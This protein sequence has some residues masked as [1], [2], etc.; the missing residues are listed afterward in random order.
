MKLIVTKDTLFKSMPVQSS[1][2]RK[3]GIPYSV[4]EVEAGRA[5]D[6]LAALPHEGSPGAAGDHV[7]LELKTPITEGSDQRRWFVYGLHAKVEGTGPENDPQDKPLPDLPKLLDTGPK[8]S[9]PG[10]SRP[11]SIH[12]PIYQEDGRVSNFTWA[13]LTKNGQRIPV[14]ATVTDRLVKLARELDWIRDYLG[15]LPIIVTSGYRDP[16][17]NW[18]VGGA[19]DSRHMYG[20]AVDFYVK[21]MNDVDVFYKLK[22]SGRR[23]GGLAVGNGFVHIDLR[24][25]ALAR[26]TYPRGPVVALW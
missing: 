4:V 21:G 19:S 2:L 25:G 18:N 5:F 17:S 12:A 26:W 9:I 6:V 13:E 23:F 7:F 22:N 16:K 3:K 15:G 8:I 1:E 20:D 14:N 24:P 10:I 11:V